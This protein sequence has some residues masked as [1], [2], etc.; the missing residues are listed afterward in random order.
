ML[1]DASLSAVLP[2]SLAALAVCSTAVASGG[3]FPT[4]WGWSAIGLTGAAVLA[5][6]LRDRVELGRLDLALLGSFGLLVVWTWVSAAWSA[7][8]AG[9]FLLGERGLVYVAGVAAALLVTRQRG[10]RPLLGGVFAA[11]TLVSVY[12]LATRLFPAHLGNFDPVATYRLEAPLGYWNALGILAV[13]GALLAVGFVAR[14]RLVATRSAAAAAL[15]ALLPTVYFTFGRGAIAALAVGVAAMTVLD[16]RR[17]QLLAAMLAAL[18]APAV[19]LW[20][21]YHAHALT[22]QTTAA[23]VAEGAGRRLAL[24]LIILACLAAWSAGVFAT[25]EKAVN[26]RPSHRRTFVGALVLGAVLVLTAVVVR[27]G[28]PVEMSRSAY[29]SFTAPPV[30]VRAGTSLNTRLFS[31]SADGRIELWRA[32]LR[33]YAAHPWLGS[34]AGTYEGYWL[35]HRQNAMKVK[36]AHSLYLEQ[37]AELG[38]LGAG[39]LALALALP[40]AAA[41]QARRHPLAA[42]A[43]GAYIAFLVHAAADWDWEMPAVTLAALFC[44]AALVVL[45]RGERRSRPLPSAGR[46]GAVAALVVVATVAFVGWI[47]NSALAAG[48]DALHG[49]Q[50]GVAQAQAHKAMRWAPWSPQPWRLLAEAQYERGDLAASRRNLATAL[51]KDPR[52]WQLWLDLAAASDGAARTHALG[53]ALALNARSPEIAQFRA[54]LST[55]E[56]GKQR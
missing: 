3:Y 45:A 24:S 1:D 12:A 16:R 15:V 50:L 55:S 4:T 10:V 11:I 30:H 47:G 28:N 54:S 5:L 23:T 32:A 21:S 46:W 19:A 39:L 25:L 34:G 29:R 9:S 48:D 6:L 14:A 8:P 40:V 27:F 42:P 43:F 52:D 33:D 22:R 49:G 31:L 35:Q 17:L 18:P 26:V 53:R 51:R 13:V 38:P 2:C 36:N 20:L 56:N 37:L 7:A 44:G 41:V